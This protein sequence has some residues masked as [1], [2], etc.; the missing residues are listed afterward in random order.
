MSSY[1]DYQY[2]GDFIHEQEGL[3]SQ[4][5]EEP[6]FNFITDF[7]ATVQARI[8]TKCSC[9]NSRFETVTFRLRIEKCDDYSEARKQNPDYPHNL[10]QIE[11]R[12]NISLPIN[13]ITGQNHDIFE[14]YAEARKN[15]E[16][17]INENN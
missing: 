12:P 5:E 2:D 17:F 13:A 14:A 7:E 4:G 1:S 10:W 6:N 8:K 11:Y 9:G 15:L 16:K 3:R